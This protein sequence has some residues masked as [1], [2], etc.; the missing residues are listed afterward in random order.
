MEQVAA[1]QEDGLFP[2]TSYGYDRPLVDARVRELGEAAAADRERAESA[3]EELRVARARIAELEALAGEAR[4]GLGPRMEKLLHA[5]EQ[6]AAGLRDSASSEATELRVHARRDA[7]AYR[8]QVEQDLRQRASE[9]DDEARKR[10]AALRQKENETE[11]TLVAAREEAERIRAGAERDAEAERAE[12]RQQAD[13]LTEAAE[14]AAQRSR[15][16]AQR[17]VDGLA[18]VR[19]DILSTIAELHRVLGAQLDT[20]PS[21]VEDGQGDRRRPRPSLSVAERRPG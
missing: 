2:A 12:A 14:R 7:E 21:S 19:D 4:G 20:P 11:E 3:T 17:E 13:G 9:M 8:H 15:E 10:T 5:A 16:S 1:G 6:E 18:R